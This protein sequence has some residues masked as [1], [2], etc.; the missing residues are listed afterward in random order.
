MYH[1]SVYYLGKKVTLTPR[2]PSTV[3]PNEDNETPRVCF[4]PSVE[5]CLLGIHGVATIDKTYTNKVGWFLYHTD[6][7]LEPAGSRVPDYHRSKEHWSLTSIE[8][9]FVGVV[10]LDKKT[11]KLSIDYSRGK[12]VKNELSKSTKEFIKQ[13][14]AKHG[15]N[16]DYSLVNVTKENSSVYIH[17]KKDGYVFKQL[18]KTHLTLETPCPICR[19]FKTTPLPAV[20]CGD[21]SKIQPTPQI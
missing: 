3:M 20:S 17:C 13:A 8:V 16:Y 14:K 18:P 1:V 6:E 19:H 7:I 11:N 12:L 21:G 2:V 4:A 5:Q 10:C 15:N 9:K